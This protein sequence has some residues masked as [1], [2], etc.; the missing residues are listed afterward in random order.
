MKSL[1]PGQDLVVERFKTNSS[2]QFTQLAD[3]SLTGT[4]FSYA[5][6]KKDQDA[7]APIEQFIQIR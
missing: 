5:A 3:S 1:I 4:D 6:I 2:D 7:V